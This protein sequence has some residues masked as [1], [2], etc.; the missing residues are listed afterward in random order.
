MRHAEGED[1]EIGFHEPL[2]LKDGARAEQLLDVCP[3]RQQLAEELGVPD[4]NARGAGH[5][6]ALDLGVVEGVQEQLEPA[7]V[8][9]APQVQVRG[10]EIGEF[11]EFQGKKRTLI[12]AEF[13]G[14]DAHHLDVEVLGQDGI[15]L[16]NA[17]GP[18]VQ[19]VSG[20]TVDQISVLCLVSLCRRP[21]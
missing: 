4:V 6:P 15:E 19:M 10:I 14:T 3:K 13:D 16:G 9:G 8:R 18:R 11:G 7:A 2:R 17:T 5:E 21:C 1:R 20:Y 12:A